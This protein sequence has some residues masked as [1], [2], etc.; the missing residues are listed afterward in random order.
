MDSSRLTQPILPPDDLARHL[1]VASSEDGSH[2]HI[3]IVGDTYTILLG[4]K[5]TAG[6]FCLIDMHVPP[7]GGPG[8]HR[9]DF[10]ETFVLL[11]GELEFV[12]RGEMKTARAGETVHIPANA[13]HVFRNASQTPARLLC[14]CAPSGQED[15]FLELGVPVSSRTEAPPKPTPEQED[16]FRKSAAEL[17]PRYK[18]ELLREPK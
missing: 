5:D 17:A 6:R 11:D 10:E 18:T 3:G 7:G 2:P 12:F 9:H 8:P 14:I 13:P 4:G 1:A 15:V 16:A